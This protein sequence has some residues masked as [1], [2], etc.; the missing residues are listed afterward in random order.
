MLARAAES[1]ERASSGKILLTMFSA[2]ALS[3]GIYYWAG[4][5]F[6]D[7]PLLNFWQYLDPELLRRD[8]L[9]SCF[10]LH[11]QP[12]L[13]NLFLGVV[14]K[15]FPQSETAAFQGLYIL[16]GLVL[17]L[18]VFLLLRRLG[19]SRVISLVV[20]TLFMVSPS[21]I[22]YEHWLFYTFPLAAILTI[23]ALLFHEV[24]A[25]RG[26]WAAHGFFASLLLLCGIRSLF[27]LSYY[28]V[29][30]GAL[31]LVCRHRRKSI[32]LASLIPF[33][34]VLSLYAK[35]R[36]LFDRFTVSS[37]MGMNVWAITTRNIPQPARMDLIAEGKLSRISLI[38]RFSGVGEYPDEFVRVEGCKDVEALTQVK[39]ST[40]F[41]NFNHCAYLSVSDRYLRDALFGLRYYPKAL[42]T[43]LSRSWFSYFKSSSDLGAP[44]DNQGKIAWVCNLYDHLFYGKIPFDL[45]KIDGLPVYSNR[46]H[47]LYLL[48]MI[49]LPLLVV[50]A[51]RS[52]LRSGKADGGLG[53]SQRILI[54][55][56]C[57]QILYVALVGN[58]FEVG[59]NNRFRFATDPLYLVLLGLFL[60]YVLVPRLGRFR[61]R[62]I[63]IP[64]PA[65]RSSH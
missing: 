63:R 52:A 62:R 7:G 65:G 29:T 23:S 18:S 64:P 35:N 60:Q 10:Y 39:K 38:K 14:L 50:S 36:I 4:V 34:I 2:F 25:G 54:F 44:R 28:L 16:S 40:G 42:A 33:L 6:D 15:L 43:G 51:L 49:G 30:A 48:L 61:L 3:H 37:W 17:Y 20:C 21:F 59:E 1:I 9:E 46:E 11:S 22:L 27:H 45:S 47:S 58:L 41:D 32:L 24:L 31:I 56:L 12:P 26:R 5:R 8:L 55:Y 19:V 13:F 53:R 57:F